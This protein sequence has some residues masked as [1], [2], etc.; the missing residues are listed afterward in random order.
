MTPIARA[1]S[2][3]K[4]ALSSHNTMLLTN[5]PKDAWDYNQVSA[6]LSEA[7]QGLEASVQNA[8]EARRVG[9]SLYKPPF[10]YEHGFIFD[11]ND[12]IFADDGPTGMLLARIRGWG[13]I[14]HAGGTTV[15][16]EAIQDEL[17]QVVADALTE[18]W[19]RH[20]MQ[21]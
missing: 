9:M 14:Q 4:L 21:A 20:T 18:F 1:I 11:S 8:S 6:K 12:H 16:A 7:V 3:M 10:K 2:A 17:G 19:D 13:Y 15:T 5:P